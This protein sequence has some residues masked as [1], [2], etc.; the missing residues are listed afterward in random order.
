MLE[1]TMVLCSAGMTSLSGSSFSMSA[2]KGARPVSPAMIQVSINT[3]SS[4]NTNTNTTTYLTQIQIHSKHSKRWKGRSP[5]QSCH[6]S[7]E[8]K[9]KCRRKRNTNINTNSRNKN[10]ITCVENIDIKMSAVKGARPVSP[11][12]IKVSINKYETNTITK[13]QQI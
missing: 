4:I 12:M 13:R 10:T 5:S 1:S 2:G 8:Q 7:C 3:N 6:D 9:Q 11:V